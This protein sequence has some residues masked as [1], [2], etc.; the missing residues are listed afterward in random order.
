[1]RVKKRELHS[2][3][4]QNFKHGRP[5]YGHLALAYY[6]ALCQG[7]DTVFRSDCYTT[8]IS[9]KTK[10]QLLIYECV[11]N[12]KVPAMQIVTMK[13][14][15]VGALRYRGGRTRVNTYF[16]EEGVF[17]KTSACSRFCKR[18]VLFVSRYEVCGGE[19]EIPLAIHEV[20]TTLTPSDSQVKEPASLLP[21]LAAAKQAEDYKILS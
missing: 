21:P 15:W 16:T 19:G 8:S 5:D 13:D 4:P 10:Q 1:M 20:Y 11:L 14:S 3:R 12:W 17:F 18:M 6:I 2:V 9:I 7:D